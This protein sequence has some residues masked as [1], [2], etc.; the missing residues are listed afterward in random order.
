MEDVEVIVEIISVLHQYYD[1][2]TNPFLNKLVSTLNEVNKGSGD[3][4]DNNKKFLLIRILSDLISL[5]I[6]P[7]S[8]DLLFDLLD[9][10]IAKEKRVN[11]ILSGIL[12]FVKY[13]GHEYLKFEHS[14]HKYKCLV[15]II[16]EERF[17][18]LIEKFFDNLCKLL[19]KTHDES[20][21]W[22]KLYASAS[23]LG[24]LISKK[25][26]EFEKIEKSVIVLPDPFPD[27]NTKSFY[28]EMKEKEEIQKIDETNLKYSNE[29]DLL[30][31]LSNCVNRHSINEWVE[32][33][34]FFKCSKKKLVSQ[35]FNV[36]KRSLDLL[37]LYSRLV[38]ILNQKEVTK[39]LVKELL[40]EF[41]SLFK[42][43]NSNLEMR[44]KN[45]R[46]CV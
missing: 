26:P 4:A 39:E 38:F 14:L 23:V 24:E 33:F 5:G 30:N 15:G 20:K 6:Y 17:T 8:T 25:V 34:H 19:K 43:Q 44:I 2:F 35:L 31:K 10:L 45:I 42:N 11:V 9:S 13:N 29:D 37:P 21:Q 22:S 27:A 3:D 7:T 36:S 41:E 40:E 12:I 18:K 16:K 46:Y 1:E 32:H 28:T